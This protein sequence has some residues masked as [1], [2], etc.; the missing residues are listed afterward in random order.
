MLRDEIDYEPP[1]RFS[2]ASRRANI[3][4]GSTAKAFRLPP[5][6]YAPM[7]RRE[8]R[9][10]VASGQWSVLGIQKIV[11]GTQ[12]QNHFLTRGFRDWPLAT[13]H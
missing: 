6:R 2:G 5:R 4:T 10:I 7:V 9:K 13:D 12:R 11:I 8:G 1:V 3:V